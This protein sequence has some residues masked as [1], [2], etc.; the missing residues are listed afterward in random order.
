MARCSAYDGNGTGPP[1]GQQI[2][3]IDS[4]KH[5]VHGGTFA[6]AYLQGRGCRIEMADILVGTAYQV[7][8]ERNLGQFAMHGQ[9]GDFVR[10]IP[11]TQTDVTSGDQGGHLRGPD[12]FKAEIDMGVSKESGF[13][14]HVYSVKASSCEVWRQA[15]MPPSSTLTLSKPLWCSTCATLRARRLVLDTSTIS[16]ALQDVIERIES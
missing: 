14:H 2:G 7:A 13:C 9:G 15:R 6:L 12:Q 4:I 3:A 8:V 1:L 16:G 5:Y 10:P 11:E